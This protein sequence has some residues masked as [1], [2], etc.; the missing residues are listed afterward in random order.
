M[1]NLLIYTALVCCF[2]QGT[3]LASD[4]TDDKEKPHVGASPSG[5]I[6][7]PEDLSNAS[8]TSAVLPVSTGAVVPVSK[9][10][11]PVA[12]SKSPMSTPSP[13]PFGTVSGFSPS[14]SSLLGSTSTTAA[15]STQGAPSRTI[16]TS[17]AVEEVPW[18]FSDAL[19][20][21]KWS[22]RMDPKT[23]RDKFTDINLGLVHE[24][25]VDFHLQGASC[26][27]WKG[28]TFRNITGLRG[29]A[30]YYHGECMIYDVEYGQLIHTKASAGNSPFST[31]YVPR[32]QDIDPASFVDLL[33]DQQ[34]QSSSTFIFLK[35]TPEKK[36]VH[37]TLTSTTYELYT[38]DPNRYFK[39]MVVRY[40]NETEPVTSEELAK[41]RTNAQGILKLPTARWK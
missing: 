38:N 28:V 7:P 39:L 22:L 31:T 26:E 40:G 10:E 20:R 11:E 6:S 14:T 16:H 30:D 9:S 3:G 13:L 34:R 2:W 8:S 35:E 29:N 27:Q 21:Q 24:W 41:L 19:V 4:G 18:G 5:S 23:E 25:I 17:E 37:H 33:I 12:L 36:P 15:S 1:K 32:C